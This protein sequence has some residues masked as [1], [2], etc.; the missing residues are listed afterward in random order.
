MK[1]IAIIIDAWTCPS[2]HIAS[3]THDWMQNTIEL[4]AQN[5]TIDSVILAS[6][7]IANEFN[8]DTIWYTNFKKFNYSKAFTNPIVQHEMAGGIQHPD[9]PT[10]DC[11]GNTPL[12]KMKKCI[13]RRTCICLLH[14]Y[15]PDKFQIAAFHPYQLTL[16]GI[17]NV[18]FFGEAW[19]ICVMDRPLGY[20]WWIE[21]TDKNLFVYE[22]GITA[23]TTGIDK[24]IWLEQEEGL[25]QFDRNYII[26]DRNSR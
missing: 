17:E 10:T 22:K 15:W 13:N 8:S 7:D 5:Q 20:N 18:Y 1:N 11:R 16:A 6:Y 2:C 9:M 21:F 4:I 23:H 3:H 12:I 19:D 25:Y 14:Y 24:T 26:F